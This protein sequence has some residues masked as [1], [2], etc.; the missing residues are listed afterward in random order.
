M[1]TATEMTELHAIDEVL[2]GPHANFSDIEQAVQ[3]VTPLYE[4][5]MVAAQNAAQGRCRVTGLNHAVILLGFNEIQSIYRTFITDI[6]QDAL[7]EGVLATNKPTLRPKREHTFNRN[8]AH[9]R[10]EKIAG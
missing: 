3:R 2:A 5:I 9:A 4:Q 7:K 10:G 6:V 1:N 8:R